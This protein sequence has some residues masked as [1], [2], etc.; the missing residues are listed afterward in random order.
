MP[1]AIRPVTHPQHDRAV[2]IGV[3]QRYG[4]MRICAEPWNAPIQSTMDRARVIVHHDIFAVHATG[5]LHAPN[6]NLC[7]L[8]P[9][10][11]SICNSIPRSIADLNSLGL[12]TGL[13]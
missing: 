3:S 5:K 10:D 13:M 2:I 9:S 11:A 1:H 12:G 4:I 6:F 8:V 7:L